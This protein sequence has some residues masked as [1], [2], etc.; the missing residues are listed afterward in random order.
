MWR[1][2]IDLLNESKKS[3]RAGIRRKEVEDAIMPDL[4]AY[5]QEKLARIVA[6]SYAAIALAGVGGRSGKR[7][8]GLYVYADAVED[9]NVWKALLAF[10]DNDIR[11]AEQVKDSLLGLAPRDANDIPGQG[12]FSEDGAIHFTL[13]EDEYMELLEALVAT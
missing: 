8:K 13:T 2:L 5:P 3:G 1:K 12:L 6:G 11:V 10:A 9:P 4:M 7:G